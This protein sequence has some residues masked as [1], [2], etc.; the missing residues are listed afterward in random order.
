MCLWTRCLKCV[1]GFPG[2]CEASR[3]PQAVPRVVPK[4]RRWRLSKL[5]EGT[6][7][8]SYVCVFFARVVCGVWV[9]GEGGNSNFCII[10]DPA[11]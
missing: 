2:C 3:L 8:F 11:V 1:G 5:C 4:D 10:M 6:V 7:C 9:V